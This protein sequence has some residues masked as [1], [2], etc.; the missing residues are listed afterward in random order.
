MESLIQWDLGLT[1]FSLF[2]NGG[3]TGGN[4]ETR[5]D[6]QSED[7]SYWTSTGPV[8]KTRLGLKGRNVESSTATV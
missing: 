8:V 1:V 6:L 3:V 2:S 7:Q 5:S 4:G